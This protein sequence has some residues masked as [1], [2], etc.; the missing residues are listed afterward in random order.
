MQTKTKFNR[1]KKKKK[2]NM[3]ISKEK[4]ILHFTT[5]IMNN[6]AKVINAEII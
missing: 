3:G 1:S 5:K 6:Q 2:K 4:Y